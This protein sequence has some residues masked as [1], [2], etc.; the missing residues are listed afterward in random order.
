MS[1][2]RPLVVPPACGAIEESFVSL[3]SVLGSVRRYVVFRPRGIDPA[4]LPT[5]IVCTAAALG[6]TSMWRLGSGQA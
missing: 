6:R 2:T 4:T 1:G 3:R 5:I